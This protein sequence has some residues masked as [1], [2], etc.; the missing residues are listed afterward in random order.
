MRSGKPVKKARKVLGKN[1]VLASTVMQ[2]IRTTEQP[3]RVKPAGLP[4]F[5][6]KF[7]QHFSPLK[8]ALSPLVEHYFYPVST[9]PINNPIKGKL[10]K[11]N[12]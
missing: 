12:K 10:K 11:G 4:Y 9:G 5:T 6:P 8:I 3:I 2:M 1:R 7:T